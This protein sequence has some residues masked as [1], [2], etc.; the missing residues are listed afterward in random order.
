MIPEQRLSTEL[1]FNQLTLPTKQPSASVARE[2]GGVALSNA[3]QGLLVKVWTATIGP[4]NSSV[5]IEAPDVPISLLFTDVNITEISLAFDQNAHPTVAYVSAGVAKLY[6]YDTVVQDFVK[7]TLQSLVGFAGA[8]SP[9]CTLDDHRQLQLGT[10]DIIVVFV[11]DG[12]LYFAA[13]RDRYGVRYLLYPD[14]N[15]AIVNPSVE[16]VCMN[17][18]LRLQIKIRGNFYDGS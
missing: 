4:G 11:Q 7:S 5:Y 10:S 6:W 15:L 3:T 18:S 1:I 17:E 12:N 9:R 8:S 2:W 13:Q 16:Y 14:I